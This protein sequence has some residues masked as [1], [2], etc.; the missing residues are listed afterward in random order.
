MPIPV[1][2]VGLKIEDVMRNLS[3]DC[4][5]TNLRSLKTYV[6]SDGRSKVWARFIGRGRNYGHPSAMP[7]TE[8]HN[9]FSDLRHGD[10]S[11]FRVEFSVMVMLVHSIFAASGVYDEYPVMDY[12][13]IAA[14]VVMLGEG[15]CMAECELAA[16]KNA[17]LVRYMI[18]HGEYHKIWDIFCR[19]V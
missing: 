2:T 8:A 14:H 6:D 9:V 15:A 5:E 19:V 4:A 3:P 12:S 1:W 10:K 7:V 16:K 11:E 13:N 17:V 18:E